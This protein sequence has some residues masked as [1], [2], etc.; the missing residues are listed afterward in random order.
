MYWSRE[1]ATST[2]GPDLIAGFRVQSTSI[3]E[4]E[5]VKGDV[6]LLV[7]PNPRGLNRQRQG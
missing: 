3:D 4:A 5:K 2:K 7:D 1:S 6:A